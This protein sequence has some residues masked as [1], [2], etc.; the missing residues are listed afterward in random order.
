MEAWFK[1]G[2]RHSLKGKKDKSKTRTNRSTV[3]TKSFLII[4]WFGQ[5][6]VPCRGGGCNSTVKGGVNVRIRETDG[7]T[8]FDLFELLQQ[9]SD[10]GEMHQNHQ[11]PSRHDKQP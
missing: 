5:L 7:L 8:L 4:N 2:Q 11:A 10:S 1:T 6:P 9:S 3:K